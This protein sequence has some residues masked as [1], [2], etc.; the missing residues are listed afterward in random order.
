MSFTAIGLLVLVRGPRE[1][2]PLIERA[3]GQFDR[4]AAGWWIEQRRVPALIKQLA[5]A[6]DPLFA[7]AQL[8][9]E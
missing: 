6:V 1:F 9:L 4:G 2:A 7:Y 8:E 3:G 5:R